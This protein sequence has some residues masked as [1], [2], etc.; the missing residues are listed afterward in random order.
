M[1]M[2]V[3]RAISEDEMIA[4]F[5]QAEVHSSR[6]QERLEALAHGLGIDAAILRTPNWHT[7][8]ENA[9]RRLL[10][11]AYRGYGQDKDYF[12]G[13][14]SDVAWSRV[15]LNRQELEQV[16]YIKY[17]YWDELSG[18][19]RLARDGARSAVVGKVVYGVSSAGFV[20]IADALRQ[21]ARFPPLILVRQD[22]DSYMV[23]VEGHARLT[24]YLIAPE[25][26]ALELEVLLGT[27]ARI[28]TWGCY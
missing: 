25:H 7:A 20:E 12:T 26:I 3:I 23:V 28:T 27:S 4:I 6:F 13:F 8:E 18:G 5:L 19:T 2:R 15:V 16:R 9:L 17:D 14:P 11:G 10:L 21:G 1:S 24:A 22:D